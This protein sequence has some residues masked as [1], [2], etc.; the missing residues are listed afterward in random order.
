MRAGLLL[1]V[2]CPKMSVFSPMRTEPRSYTTS[3][4]SPGTKHNHKKKNNNKVA[5]SSR[6]LVYLLLLFLC[7]LSVSLSCVVNRLGRVSFRQVLSLLNY[8]SNETETAPVT[9][10][11]LQ[12]NTIYRL[13]DKRQESGLVSRMKV[14][15]IYTQFVYSKSHAISNIKHIL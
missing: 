8:M 15:H 9:E 5:E 13:L 4:L 1:S 3:L 10:A 11:L 6:S 2:L 12:L 14:L 7:S